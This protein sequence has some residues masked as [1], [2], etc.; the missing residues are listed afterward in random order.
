MRADRRAAGLAQCA[1]LRDCVE[2]CGE[3]L[4]GYL[5]GICAEPAL[6]GKGIGTGLQ[7]VGRNTM[8][9]APGP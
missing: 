3:G 8:R 1:L 7:A 6:R 4:A 9:L 2:G 5:E